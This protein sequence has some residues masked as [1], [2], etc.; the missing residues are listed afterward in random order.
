[1]RVL[2]I[3]DVQSIATNFEKQGALV[4]LFRDVQTFRQVEEE[5]FS[6]VSRV[7]LVIGDLSLVRGSGRLAKYLEEASPEEII[8]LAS[9]D[10]FD[11]VV[12]A[13]ITKKVKERS[14]PDFLGKTDCRKAREGLLTNPVRWDRVL[15]SNPFLLP[16]AMGA[17]RSRNRKKIVGML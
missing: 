10:C 5:T 13:R 16:M 4:R 9:R 3:G 12:L 15:A 8:C 7:P 17:V 1:M 11:A 2:I 6:L 14:V